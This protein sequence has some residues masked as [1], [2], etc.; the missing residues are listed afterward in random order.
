MMKRNASRVGRIANR[1]DFIIDTVVTVIS[2][3][4]LIIVL[5]P[6]IFVFSASISEPVNVLN[7]DVKLWPVGFTLEGYQRILEYKAIWRGYLNAII[8]TLA[9]I[10]VTLATTIPAAYALSRKELHGRMLF[11]A[12]FAVTMFFNAGLIPTYLAIKDYGMLNTV[13]S[14]LL[15][16]CVTMSNLIVVRT[17][18]NTSIPYDLSEAAF[19]DGCSNFQLFFKIMVPLAKPVIAVIA[20]FAAVGQWNSYFAPLI[21]LSDSAKYPLQVHLRNILIMGETTDIMGS[22]AEELA[23]IVRL[24]QLRESMKYGLI[25]VSALPMLCFYPFVQKF[26]MKGIMMGSIKG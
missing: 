2:V 15:P 12:F 8:Y 1:D 25:I 23:N 6:L 16:G 13:W 17:Y 9:S 22:D 21:Y 10:V 5:Y 11:T 4:A 26:F 24:Q 7:G 20:L 14:I 18:F 19:I 3:L